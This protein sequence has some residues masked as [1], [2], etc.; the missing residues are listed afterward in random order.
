MPS[1]SSSSWLASG[2]ENI[3]DEERIPLQ[4]Q[5]SSSS[6]HHEDLFT[7]QS[8]K[9]LFRIGA[10]STIIISLFLLTI[11]AALFQTNKDNLMKSTLLA[12]D[13]GELCSLDSKNSEGCSNPTKFIV[14]ATSSGRW[15]HGFSYTIFKGTAELFSEN[16]EGVDDAGNRSL[17]TNLG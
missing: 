12:D 15:P 2:N 1:S 6:E 4:P 3:E 9:S 17:N 8:D 7:I 5:S 14:P 16:G 11:G 13:I 10:A